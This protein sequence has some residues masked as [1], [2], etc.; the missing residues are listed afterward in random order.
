MSRVCEGGGTRVRP[1]PSSNAADDWFEI[2]V[3][4]SPSLRGLLS[5]IVPW[6]ADGLS[7][8]AGTAVSPVVFRD[9]MPGEC[10]RH[11]HQ[12]RPLSG[13]C[14]VACVRN[15]HHWCPLGGEVE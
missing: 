6:G 14:C 15:P 2:Y 5:L 9:K 8:S 3:V 1:F 12:F 10:R 7:T 11:H 13:F 4:A